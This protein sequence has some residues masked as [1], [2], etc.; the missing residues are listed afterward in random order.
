VSIRA[1]FVLLLAAL[2]GGCKREAP[3][4]APAPQAAAPAPTPKNLLDLA[5]GASIVS[6]TAEYYYEVTAAHAID[7]DQA[8]SW[9]TP[10]AGPEQ[11]VVVALATRSRIRQLGVH[12][13]QLAAISTLRVESSLD[14][15]TWTPAGTLAFN[16]TNKL[17]QVHPVSFEAR[18]L[19]IHTIA[20]SQPF[21]AIGDLIAYGEEL[22]A[23]HGRTIDGCWTINNRAAR[24][25]QRGA[26][27]SGVIDAW[28]RGPA[29]QVHG[30]FDG[31]TYRLMWRAGPQWGDAMMTVAP[32][33]VAVSGV[34]RHKTP[35]EELRGD[36]WLGTPG[37]CATATIDTAAVRARALEAVGRY[38]L[39]ALRFDTQ[40]R[41]LAEPSAAAL[42]LIASLQSARLV[43]RT[44]PPCLASLR[45]TLA[46]RG[47]DVTRYEFADRSR[48]PARTPR[49]HQA[50]IELESR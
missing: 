27:V 18:Y 30:G 41:V 28:E 14:G 15:K 21:A 50:E 46:A 48:E 5:N 7:Y 25:T 17:P 9:I 36:G 35:K 23:P 13:L 20:P 11:T 31:R 37:P 40:H 24:F 3:V 47:V 2:A 12:T 1:A 19:R 29:I 44:C 45:E 10:P 16:N 22:D 8:T 38:P 39:F 43:T 49:F 4:P 34:T 33:G 42:D 32:E 26:E 6:R